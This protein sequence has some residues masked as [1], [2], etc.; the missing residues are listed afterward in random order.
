MVREIAITI[1]LLFFSIIF[2][3]CKWLPLQKK[4]VFVVSFSEN[5]KSILKE[6]GRQDYSCRTIFL[7]TNKLYSSFSK[8]KSSTV[9][10]FEVKHFL[11]FVQSIYHLAT[12]KVVFV[13]NYY[14]FL[15]KV[16]F[17]KEVQCIQLWH[18][19]GA[20]KKF[21]LQDPSIQHR[22]PR[23]IKRFKSVYN[24]F[25]QVIVGSEAMAD[26]FKSAF[27]LNENKILRTGIPRTDIFFRDKAK[28]EIIKRVYNSY[29]YL[30]DK[31][32]ILYAPTYRD[33]ALEDFSLKL[34]LF[35]LHNKVGSDSIVLLK[36]HPAVKNRV[37]IP[38]ELAGFVYDFSFYTNLNELL[39]ISDILITDYSSI[40]FEYSILNKPIIFFLYDIEYYQ[41][42][43]GLWENYLEFLPGPITYTT[44]EVIDLLIE[45]KFDN[46]R[47][48]QFC[49]KWNE[50]SKG[51]SSKNIVKLIKKE[52]EE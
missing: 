37:S 8:Y 21:G 5:N 26:I 23:A 2:K 32:I 27:N 34:D 13:D 31:K 39:F 7:T 51:D 22:S 49:E 25:N 9:L 52:L 4:V 50:Y 19:A 40:P 47:I 30:K 36:L 1:Y 38:E 15:A 10:L 12:S 6:M 46:Q 18:A 11:Q 43:R 42:A 45:E 17:K 3:I 48:K 14:G 41:K 28:T 20:I 24:N 29:P 33:N 44:D 35:K 16:S